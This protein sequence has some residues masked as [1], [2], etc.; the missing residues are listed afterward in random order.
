MIQV[1]SMHKGLRAR[2][3][4]LAQVVG[5]GEGKPQAGTPLTTE[6]S[7]LLSL[8][9]RSPHL[10]PAELASIENDTL[11]KVLDV[12]GGGGEPVWQKFPPH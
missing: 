11:L 5:Y 4:Q 9:I 10:G 8:G 3:R 7:H 1:E 2:R 12:E 6:T